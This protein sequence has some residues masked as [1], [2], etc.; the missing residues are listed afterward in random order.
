MDTP[1]PAW[2][3]LLLPCAL[4]L[5][6]LAAGPDGVRWLAL[7]DDAVAMRAAWARHHP[8]PPRPGAVPAAWIEAV[9]A[10]LDGAPDA[11]PTPPLA[12]RGTPFQQRV[13][14][15]LRAIP[16]GAT[17]TYGALATR[18][19]QPRAARAVAAACAANPI[20]VLVPCHRVVGADGAL[21]GY[22]W[23]LERK[24]ALLR[25]EGARAAAS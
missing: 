2:E 22:R 3:P 18:L 7:G 10:A 16:P 8:G 9:R 4:G 19:G 15:E 5:A 14:A 1:Q 12:P 24:R 23:G 20:A 6:L 17:A 11:A 13:W 21:T 25:R